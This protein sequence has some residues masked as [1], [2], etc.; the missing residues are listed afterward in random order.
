MGLVTSYGAA[1][2]SSVSIATGYVLDEQGVGVQVRSRIVSSPR[3]PEQL[4]VPPSI[5]SNGYR[6]FFPQG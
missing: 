5:L 4:W 6:G 2:D 3:R 1:W